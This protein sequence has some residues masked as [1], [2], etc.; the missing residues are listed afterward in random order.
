VS[1]SA[2]GPLASELGAPAVDAAGPALRR[3]RVT[4]DYHV[5][6]QVFSPEMA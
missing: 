6:S 2:A 5:R 4:G 1:L 3:I